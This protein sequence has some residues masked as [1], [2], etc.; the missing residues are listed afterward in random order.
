MGRTG[1]ES[2]AG[3]ALAAKALVV[4]TQNQQVKT[5]RKNIMFDSLCRITDLNVVV[6]FQKGKNAKRVNRR[7]VI[8]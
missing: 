2:V 6:N 4:T 1:W 3:L 5:N 7:T 8:L